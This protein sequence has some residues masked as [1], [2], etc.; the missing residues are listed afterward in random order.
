MNSLDYDLLYYFC[1]DLLLSCMIQ[2]EE[3][4]AFAQMSGLL[5]VHPAD[6][7]GKQ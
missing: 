3:M 4:E 6:K 5:H 7:K 2:V 1:P